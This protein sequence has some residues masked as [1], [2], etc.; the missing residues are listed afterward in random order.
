MQL[1][2]EEAALKKEDDHLS[3]ER[4]AH[5]Q[6]ELAQ[7]REDFQLQKAKWDEDKKAVEGV[8]TIRQEIEDLNKQIEKAQREY[9]LNKAAELQYGRLPQLKKQLEEEEAKIHDRKTHLSVNRLQRM[10]SPRSCPGGPVFL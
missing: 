10:R 1:E 6:E 2:I 3:Q 8:Q 4:L 5:I 9:D 7:L